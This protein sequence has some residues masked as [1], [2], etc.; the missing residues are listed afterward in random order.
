MIVVEPPE[1]SH[2]LALDHAVRDFNVP[3]LLDGH[4]SDNVNP[5]FLVMQRAL[6]STGQD[7]GMII[8]YFSI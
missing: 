5:R 8:L 7:I 1:Y 4:K 3:P 6:V 2:I